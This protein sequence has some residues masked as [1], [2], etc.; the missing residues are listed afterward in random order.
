MAKPTVD[1]GWAKNLVFIP[2][3]DS[4]GNSVVVANR[5]EPSNDY[6]NVG[7]QPNV[8]V[9]G[10]SLN[11]KLY[12]DHAMIEWLRGMDV[13]VIL[14]FEDGTMTLAQLEADHGGTWEDLG[15]RIQSWSTA[16]SVTQRGFKKVAD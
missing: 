4:D 1:T 11:Y 9:V 16:G 7:L 2:V 10:D 13:G 3:T 15:T 5:L 12:A 8:P 6:K 14:E